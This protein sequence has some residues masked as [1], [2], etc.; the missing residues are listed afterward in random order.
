MSTV[1]PIND[2]EIHRE[3]IF[4]A[5]RSRVWRAFTEPALIAQWWGRGHKL[6]IEK[7]ELFRGGH[8]RYVEHAPSG[9]QGFEGRFREVTPEERIVRSFEWDGM[10][11]H[12]AIETIVLEDL[13]DGRTKV[14]STLLLHTTGERDGMYNAGMEAGMNAA[15][16]ALDRV[17]AATV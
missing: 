13:G 6:D 3:R 2:R 16:A 5:S 17:L 1:T 14:I 11:A 10:P 7:L 4:N 8:W 12:V 15:Y 9:A